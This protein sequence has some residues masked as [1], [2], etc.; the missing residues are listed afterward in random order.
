[1]NTGD[2]LDPKTM[3]E[4]MHGLTLLRF[5]SE[6]CIDELD[7]APAKML[8][9]LQAA[10]K[11][12]GTAGEAKTPPPRQPPQE[13]DDHGGAGCCGSAEGGCCGR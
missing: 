11:A 2:D 10:R 4:V 9:K 13:H 12:K 8:A 5:G 6:D 3:V 7:N 1:M